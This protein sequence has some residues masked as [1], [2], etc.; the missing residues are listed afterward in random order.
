M[1]SDHHDLVVAIFQN[2]KGESLYPMRHPKICPARQ[3]TR[4]GDV[5]KRDKVVRA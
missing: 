4:A 2:G 5:V 3:R 1:K